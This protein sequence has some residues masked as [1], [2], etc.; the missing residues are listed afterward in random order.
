MTSAPGVTNTTN[1]GVDLSAVTRDYT[2]PEGCTTECAV[3]PDTMDDNNNKTVCKQINTTQTTS[4]APWAESLTVGEMHIVQIVLSAQNAQQ[5][6]VVPPLSVQAKVKLNFP[7]PTI[8][9][10]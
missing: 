6:P 3:D 5:T 10:H 4:V 7:D 2:L 8:S 1:G 9:V